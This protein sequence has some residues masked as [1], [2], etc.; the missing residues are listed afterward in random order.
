LL[1]GA[2]FATL[3]LTKGQ[4]AQQS[5]LE[6]TQRYGAQSLPLGELTAQLGTKS[7]QTGTLTINGQLSV[8]DSLILQPGT[9]PSQPTIGQL[10][11]DKATNLLGY[12]NG[13]TFVILQ[14]SGNSVVTNNLT[15]VTNIAGG[16]GGVATSGGTAGHLALFTSSNAL[17]DAF[18]TQAGPNLSVGSS[19]GAAATSVQGGT[20][21][22]SLTTGDQ[23]GASGNIILQSGAST[24]TSSGDVTIDTGSGLVNGTQIE[25]YGFEAGIEHTIPY[26]GTFTNTQ[27]CT[28]SHT[29]NC[30][31]NLTGSDPLS[32]GNDVYTQQS[33]TPGSPVVPGHHYYFTIY[34]KAASTPATINASI[35]GLGPFCDAN[36]VTDSALT[37]TQSSWTCIAPPGATVANF[38]F[39]FNSGLVQT[40]Y[41]D[42]L[43]MIDLSSSTSSS[44]LALGA[45]NAQDVTLGNINEIGLTSIF[46]GSGVSV[47]SGL[48]NLSLN[49][50]TF[51][52]G[53]TAGGSINTT[54]AALNINGGSLSLTGSGASSFQTSAGSLSLTSADSATWK[55][56]P[57]ATGDGGALTIKSGNAAAGN[58]NGGNLLLQ[59][60]LATGTGTAGSVIVKSQTDSA[61]A[62]QV[63]N[64]S[65]TPLLTANTLTMTITVQ[66]LIVAADL[67]FD[68]HIITGG[69]PPTV[70]AG[71]AACTSPTVGLIGND[72]SGTITVTTGTACPGG[73]ILAS[74]N[75]VTVFTAAPR[76]TLTPGNASAQA[77]G[78]Y[79]DDATASVSKFDLGTGTAPTATTTYKWNYWVAQ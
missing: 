21:G 27:D 43:I 42:D 24:T 51:N 30:S 17:G 58:N 54:T 26:I 50:G 40:H 34:S 18:I 59:S 45:T 66:K 28:V 12:Y 48:G 36:T 68:G 56:A 79:V 7:N 64:S 1:G 70:A 29:G 4:A 8:N 37:W 39:G 78:A 72:T 47:N 9:K 11:Y 49:G 60:G 22:L 6:A 63:Q 20:N 73:G 25:D 19:A 53:S 14:G 31:L 77:L 32:G 74:V 23:T 76:V 10:Y 65:G 3:N 41:F 57:A 55:V 44:S 38:V 33:S 52:L 16:G 15:N 35:S 67:T 61:L 69:S 62:F 75:F 71:P 46:G 13:A 5:Q 2:T